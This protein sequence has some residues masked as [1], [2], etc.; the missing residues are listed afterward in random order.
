[1]DIS[2]WQSAKL[3]VLS[4]LDL[5][6]DALHIYVGL[7]VFLL[8]ALIF[9]RPIRSLVPWLT[10]LAV[11]ALGEAVDA[12]ENI[13]SLGQWQRAASVHDLINTL[14]WPT[15]LHLLARFTDVLDHDET[16]L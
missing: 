9:R 16:A 8:A 2:S 1:M 12:I 6:K 13:R 7:L 11:A 5:S 15:I 14:V 10:V 4:A 3:A